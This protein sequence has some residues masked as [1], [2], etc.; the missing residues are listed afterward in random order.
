M[1]RKQTATDGSDHATE[2]KHSGYDNH[3]QGSACQT[4][5]HQEIFRI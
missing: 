4:H 5:F 3:K 2:K 1:R